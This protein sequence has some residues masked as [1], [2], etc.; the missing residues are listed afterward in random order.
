MLSLVSSSPRVLSI[1]FI[2]CSIADLNS[3][4]LIQSP[5]SR[6][7]SLTSAASCARFATKRMEQNICLHKRSRRTSPF[8]IFANNH[9]SNEEECEAGSKIPCLP[10]IGASSFDGES[11]EDMDT[12]NLGGESQNVGFVGQ[13]FELQYTCKICETR[14]SHKVSRL[15][16]STVS[17]L[18]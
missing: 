14:N 10:P 18:F 12:I 11:S 3:S 8:V 6:Y 17:Y 1:L 15:G 13:K 9:D 2:L 16:T 4:L 5:N 7:L